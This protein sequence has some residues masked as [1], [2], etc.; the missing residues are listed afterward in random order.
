MGC[1]RHGFEAEFSGRVR[2]LL[3]QGAASAA[4]VSGTPFKS[5]DPRV[6]VW[7]SSQSACFTAFSALIAVV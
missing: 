1:S 3:V 6:E 5:P 7:G 2:L 4:A